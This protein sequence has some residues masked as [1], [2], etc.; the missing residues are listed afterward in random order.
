MNVAFSL[1]LIGCLCL[2]NTTAPDEEFFESRIRPILHDR[3]IGCHGADEQHGALRLDSR[4]A[5][6]H[7]GESGPAAIPG[8]PS[9]SLLIN[10]IRHDNAELRMPPNDAGGKLPDDAIDDFTAWV[11]SGLA[12][13]KESL[14]KG[15]NEREVF[16]IQ[17][18]KDRLPWIW[19]PPKQQLVPE[20]TDPLVVGDID[21]FI[22]DKLRQN[23][24][25]FAP[26]ADELTWLR[27]S[28]FAITG[29]P[30]TQEQIDSFLNDASVDRKQHAV[31]ELLASS[32]FGERWARHWMD[33][34]RYA[35]SRGHESDFSI[36][37][38]WQYRDYLIRA[39]NADLPYD[40]FVMEH[41]AGDLVD[42]RQNA[43]TGANESVIAT[44]WAFLG[45]EVH[46][47][48]DIR[49]DEC[50]R[51][52]NKIDVLSKSFLG[53]TIACARCHDHKFDAISQRDYYALSGFMLGSAF[54]QSRFA[55]MVE[56]RQATVD[57]ARL[58]ENTQ[59]ILKKVLADSLQSGTS[60]IAGRLMASCRVLSGEN[61]RTVAQGTGIEPTELDAWIEQLEKS[62][63]DPTNP[64]RIFHDLAM[65]LSKSDGSTV[66]AA[67][68]TW[69]TPSTT[70]P[71]G[72]FV[73]A[74]FTQPT[75]SEWWNS[76]GPGF[77]GRPMLEG[78]AV[79]G[80]PEKPITRI[81]QY[82]AAVRDPF[83]KPLA[84]TASTETDSGRFGAVNRAGKTL[85]TP[86]WTLRSGNV[87][88]LVRGKLQS[89]AVVDSHIMNEGPL[90]GSLIA[91]LDSGEQLRWLTHNLTPYTGHRVHLE[92][93]PLGDSDLEILTLVDSPTTPN[94][95]PQRSWIPDT[96]PDSIAELCNLFQADSERILQAWKSDTRNIE[97][98]L[99][100][101][102]NWMVQNPNLL[103]IDPGT[104]VQTT[105]DY[106]RE[107][108]VIS[109]S[110]RWDSPTAVSLADIS[111]VDENVLIRGKPTRLGVI[112]NR[113]L[114][115]AFG[116][117]R[118]T[119]RQSSGRLELARQLVDP[120]N[121][122]VARVMVNRVWH[123][124]FGR[125]IVPTVDNFGA[126][127][128]RPS[129]PELLDHLAWEFMH[130][131]NWSLKSLIRKIVL[132]KTFA[133]SSRIN[134]D[135]DNVDP[136][137]ALLHR[138]PIRRLEGEA[139]RDSL[140]V[141]SGRLDPKPYGSPIPVYL[142]E[143]IIGRGRPDV[144]GPLDGSG[145]RSIY[146]ATRRNFLPTMMLAFDFPTPFSS[147]GRRNVTNVPAQSLTMLN[148]PFVREQ[149]NVLAGRLA[150]EQPNTDP[151][152]RIELLFKAAYCRNP[153]SEEVDLS[154][155]TIDLLRTEY[156]GEPD[157]I[158]WTEFCHAIFLA[159]E[160]IYVK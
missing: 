132:S 81:M 112:V 109:K 105:S 128:D 42:A 27:R 101:I 130:Q 147:I 88:I 85:L 86:K 129:H 50:E 124:L 150:K 70:Q 25:A 30:P 29:L 142:T 9:E 156:E 97:P 26:P 92:L 83:W 80:S 56:H 78:E 41:I 60:N 98:R 8:K 7:G 115:E 37:N 121:P 48:V 141:L 47:P 77:G 160:F 59:S 36:A 39:F 51:V 19:A 90:H 52:D 157:Q 31:D 114:P 2:A 61:S 138:M 119:T 158:V 146:I 104:I 15:T 111:G 16:D 71:L 117:P 155:Q 58:R 113:G 84:L 22:A 122:L 54:R 116:T 44:G 20:N 133:Q 33:L 11:Q 55:T 49:Q 38:A 94:W 66:R 67:I 14:P 72:P 159:N 134:P 135:A 148:D 106:F 127:G 18:R 17:A 125:G 12:W 95:L 100:A 24:L 120:T 99:L 79:F 96:A 82:S 53:L 35:E 21:R 69:E 40:R 110:L 68:S 126:L 63:T 107:L 93:S 153:T 131:E 57:L 76:D 43:E 74:D 64:L 46:S 143:F 87:H 103:K 151:Q 102:A 28:Y 62:K 45:E 91:H 149:A 1:Y 73:V 139:I 10:A 75:A 154:L 145:R 23:G 140:L 144:S 6:L 13:P 152:T 118:V 32:H 3:C 137:N 34:M 4:E 123:H 65:R 136:F 89:C 5:I 108:D